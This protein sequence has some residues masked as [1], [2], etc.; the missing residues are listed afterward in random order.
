MEITRKPFQGLINI[1]WFN[2]HYYLIAGL[3]GF[4]L[5]LFHNSIPEQ[6]RP[7]VYFIA[8]SASLSLI[9]SVVVSYY[10]YDFSNLYHLNWLP[11]ISFK[12]VLTINAGFDETS[13][14]IT[15][16]FSNVSL[17]ICD[18]YDKDKHTE[19]SIKRAR[20]AYPP[21]HNTISVS[22]NKLPFQENTFDYSLAILS[23]H[24]IRD[25]SERI[26]FFKEL[27]RVTKPDGQ[28]FVT[29]HLRDFNNFLAFTVGFFHFHSKKVWI[30]TFKSAGL[31]VEKE[32]KTT[33]FITTF[34]LS[35]NGISL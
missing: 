18:F 28:I 3:A 12:N 2:W 23:A 33:P 32:I 15:R 21:A 6:L 10:I 1:L 31:T 29:E 11:N 19:V 16:I 34:I 14:I 27:D 26:Q 24:E 30:E 22:T 20:R 7:I 4:V 9:V 13:E 25:K 5:I 17:T 35:H 8:I